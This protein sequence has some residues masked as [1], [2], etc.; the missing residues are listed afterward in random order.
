M[1]DSEPV[2]N[3]EML[4]LAEYM[5]ESV[6]C[7]YYDAVHAM[8]PT[9]LGYKLI[10]FYS[11]NTEFTAFSLLGDPE[12]EVY[13]FL[14]SSG[15]KPEEEIK[16]TFGVDSSLLETLVLKRAILSVK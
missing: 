10:D 11:A 13:D 4:L 7:T 9:G 5:H 3:D 12:K 1:I 16:K 2:L 15:E 6:F 8:L 14:I